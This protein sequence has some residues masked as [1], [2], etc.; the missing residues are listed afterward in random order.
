MQLLRINVLISGEVQIIVTY[1]REPSHQ[2]L[3]DNDDVTLTCTVN[4]VENI[5]EW[6]NETTNI[7]RCNTN[8]FCVHDGDIDTIKYTFSFSSPGE[9]RLRKN[10][11]SP[12]TDAGVYKCEHE[13]V[14]ASVT[15]DAC[16]KFPCI[17]HIP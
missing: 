8:G 16:G 17:F 11:I 2:C 6:L 12:G 10:P 9:F 14:S 7:G 13:G 5:V 15:L 4:P 3:H 1:G